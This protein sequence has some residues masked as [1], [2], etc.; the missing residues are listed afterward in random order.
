MNKKIALW[1]FRLLN[2]GKNGMK[3]IKEAALK[4]S[5]KKIKLG[6][7]FFLKQAPK[8]KSRLFQKM[9]IWGGLDSRHSPVCDPNR[10]PLNHQTQ[11]SKLLLE[12]HKVALGWRQAPSECVP[13][14]GASLSSI[15]TLILHPHP[16]PPSGMN[17]EMVSPS[18][19]T[20]NTQQ[21]LLQAPRT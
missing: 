12:Q 3:K 11:E 18:T 20:P 17:M 19:S 5:I 4:G 6:G 16:H 9:R 15:L 1:K 7:F 21:G 14:F 13:S 10:G 2:R 8:I